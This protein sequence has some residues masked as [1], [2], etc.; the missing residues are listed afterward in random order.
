MERSRTDRLMIGRVL[1]LIS[2]L[3]GPIIYEKPSNHLQLQ[4]EIQ[5]LAERDPDAL[6]KFLDQQMVLIPEGNYIRGDDIGR[7]DEK[8]AQSVYLDAFA[9]DRFEVTN[10]QYQQFLRS[11]SR[12]S[13]RYWIGNQYPKGQPHYPVL[14]VRWKDAEAYCAWA[15]KRLPTEAEWEKACRGSNGSIYPWGDDLIPYYGN[16]GVPLKGPGP[17][18]WDSLWDKLQSPEHDGFPAPA[19]IGSYPNGISVYGVYDLVGNASEWVSDYYNWDGYGTVPTTNPLVLEPPWNHVIRGSS[20][21]MPY[22]LV[23]DGVDLN[24]CSTRSSS[25]GD[26]RDARTGFRCAKDFR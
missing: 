25:H 19:A 21:V 8:P 13:P 4:V 2:L 3:V 18:F 7:D 26:T 20:W 15:G 6:A 12:S 24:R 17:G 10:C 1:I 5:Q 22:G 14:G 11:N 23:M 9:I 16:T